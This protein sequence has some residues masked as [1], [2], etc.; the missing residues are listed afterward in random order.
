MSSIQNYMELKL[1]LGTQW[2]VELI[3]ELRSEK[4]KALKLKLKNNNFQ[5]L[6]Q[7]FWDKIGRLD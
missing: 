6:K 5:E 3:L 7:T 2:N 4:L 1:K